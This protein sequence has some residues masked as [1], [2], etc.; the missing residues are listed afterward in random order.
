MKADMTTTTLCLFCGATLTWT[1]AF[2]R[3]APKGF[4]YFDCGR[5][6]AASAQPRSQSRE[7]IRSVSHQR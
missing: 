7:A 4:S 1:T 6:K 3:T 5:H 2:C